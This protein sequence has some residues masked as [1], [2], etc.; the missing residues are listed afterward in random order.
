LMS[1]S[2]PER[3]EG[4]I[5]EKKVGST[6][7]NNLKFL[8][9]QLS[10]PALRSSARLLILIS[11]SI[12]KKLSFL[13]LLALT[14]LGK[15]SLENHIEKL[16]A[17]EYVTARNI[18]TFSGVREVVEITKKGQEKCSSLLKGLQDVGKSG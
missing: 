12:N 2:D 14:G 4:E 11:L 15:G 10:D 18:K 5:S 6:E 9:S 16:S 7:N 3:E 13:E 8:S 1:G 17:S